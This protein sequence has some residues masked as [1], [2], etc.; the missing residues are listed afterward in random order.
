MIDIMQLSSA[1]VVNQIANFHTFFN[2]GTTLLVLMC[3]R[4]LLQFVYWILPQNNS[5]K[6]IKK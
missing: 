4:F 3:D 1:H 6:K 2:V 5:M